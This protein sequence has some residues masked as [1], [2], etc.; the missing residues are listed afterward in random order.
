MEDIAKNLVVPASHVPSYNPP[1]T[2]FRIW[3]HKQEPLMPYTYPFKVPISAVAL[4]AKQHNIDLSQYD[5]VSLRRSIKRILSF[6]PQLNT[7][8][9][10]INNVI[11]CDDV[12]IA[13]H[14]Q[15]FNY[16][17][18]FEI[19]C[20]GGGG[21]EQKQKDEVKDKE[22]GREVRRQNTNKWP[23]PFKTENDES[24]IDVED[25]IGND[26]KIKMK[27]EEEKKCVPLRKYSDYFQLIEVQICDLKLLLCSEIDCVD[28]DGN[29]MEVKFGSSDKYVSIWS[30]CFLSG[31]REIV[32]AQK[33]L[34]SLCAVIT[35]L[36]R[37]DYQS[38]YASKQHQ[39]AQLMV[40]YNILKYIQSTLM[41]NGE[42]KKDDGYDVSDIYRLSR[43]RSHTQA[44]LFQVGG[45]DNLITEE[46]W[47]Y[48][49]EVKSDRKEEK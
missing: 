34:Q 18:Q 42:M 28:K 1:P 43:H 22:I 47:K 13:A 2:P 40:F 45:C 20:D 37:R 19:C 31:I 14:Y 23:I 33:S 15:P 10:R 35:G 32:Q 29:A 6:S 3:K 12:P 16:G 27:A 30:Q 48:L 36:D 7:N 38:Y 44:T 25:V 11:F 5:F 24:S 26:V 17:Y 8:F 21:D 49:N 41:H 39:N 46:Q 9:Q 4:S